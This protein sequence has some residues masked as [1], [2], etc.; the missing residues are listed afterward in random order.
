MRYICIDKFEDMEDNNYL[1]APGEEFPREGAPAPSK[2]RIEELLKGYNQRG[3]RLI[4]ELKLIE[5]IAD[6][7]EEEKEEAKKKDKPKKK[8]A[9]K[10]EK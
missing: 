5:I 7:A 9:T 2:K 4:A 10:K 8:T 3:K 6:H 1:Y